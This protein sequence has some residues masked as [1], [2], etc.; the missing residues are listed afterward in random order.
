[1]SI[2]IDE[3]EP[4]PQGR[5]CVRYPCTRPAWVLIA[6]EHTNQRMK[7]YERDNGY[8]EPIP[9]PYCEAHAEEVAKKAGWE[10]LGELA[11]KLAGNDGLYST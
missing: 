11:L 10:S 7:E 2:Y 8:W 6:V 9:L 3:V 1:M 5:R 4:A